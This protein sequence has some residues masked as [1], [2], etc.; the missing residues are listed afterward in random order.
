YLVAWDLDREDWRIFRV[1]RLTPRIPTGPRFSPRPLPAEDAATF[2]AER[3]AGVRAVEHATFVVRGHEDAV[4]G[5]LTARW[6]EE[7][8][9]DGDAPAEPG[10]RVLRLSAGSRDELVGYLAMLGVEVE[11]LGPPELLEH[12]RASA[13]RLSRAVGASA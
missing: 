6:V 8:V 12:V 5:W 1:D 3:M 7:I 13:D 11:L 10:A 9:P 4:S 2:V